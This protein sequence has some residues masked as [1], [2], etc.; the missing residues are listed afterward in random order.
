[1]RT[2]KREIRLWAVSVLV[3]WSIKILPKDGSATNYFIWLSKM[4][5]DD[6]KDINIPAGD[7]SLNFK[8]VWDTKLPSSAK[9]DTSAY[10]SFKIKP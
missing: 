1:M 7:K 8:D 2:L 4:P 10:D 6:G 9:C 3:G 5:P